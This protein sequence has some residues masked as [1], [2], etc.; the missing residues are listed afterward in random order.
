[1]LDRAPCRCLSFEEFR[2][3]SSFVSNP[4]KECTHESGY[5]CGSHYANRLYRLRVVVSFCPSH[6]EPGGTECE[7]LISMGHRVVRNSIRW[8]GIH[9]ATRVSAPQ[10][11]ISSDKPESDASRPMV[12][13]TPPQICNGGISGPVWICSAHVGEYF[14][15]GLSVV[16]RF[17]ASAAD[18]AAGNR[19]ALR[20]AV[21]S[22]RRLRVRQAL[23]QSSQEAVCNKLNLVLEGCKN[24]FEMAAQISMYL[25][26]SCRCC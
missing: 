15:P 2:K 20:R 14:H 12:F 11:S 8:D 25:R 3:R 4:R 18:M 26:R 10:C 9:R 22:Q 19:P 17:T 16:W 21:T 6:T 13:G 1:M 24:E 7:R 23:P 5:P